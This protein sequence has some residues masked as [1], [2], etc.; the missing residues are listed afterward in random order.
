L[1]AVNSADKPVTV[2]FS[3]FPA[4]ETINAFSGKAVP[5]GPENGT[6]KLTFK[7]LEVKGYIF[8]RK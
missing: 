7:P 5:I 4:V 8:N 6:F 2:E 1:I 3:G